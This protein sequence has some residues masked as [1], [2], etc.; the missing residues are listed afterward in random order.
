M[1]VR[2]PPLARLYFAGDLAQR[3]GR[4]YF[5]RLTPLVTAEPG[6]HLSAG[7]PHARL[8][9]PPQWFGHNPLLRQGHA[10]PL[11]IEPVKDEKREA[12]L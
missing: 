9:T 12:S 8:V 5:Y 2:V 6:R 1:R 7:H 11:S 4:R 3:A 10:Q